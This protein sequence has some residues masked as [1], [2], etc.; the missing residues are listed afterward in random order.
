MSVQGWTSP[1]EAWPRHERPLAQKALLA[2]R[3]AD[4]WLKKASA[5]S[6]VWGVITCGEPTLPGADRCSI[7]VMCTSGRPDGSST[8]KAI[9]DFIRKCP[10]H[11]GSSQQE[12]LLSKAET[13]VVSAELCVKA[14]EALATA[15]SHR[16]LVEDYLSKSYTDL[17][18]ADELIERAL[19]EDL[20]AD[21]AEREAGDAAEAAGVSSDL[22]AVSIAE[23]ASHRAGKAIQFVEHD[24]SRRARVI[25]A[26]CTE[27]KSRASLLRG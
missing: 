6:K 21:E 17:A 12:D 27:V 24:T 8:K 7:S 26:R 10:H 3:L 25:R 4:W 2:A 19:E 23:Q 11:R 15:A 22:A 1:S 5:R 13:L 9:D 16:D 14:A 20:L 18:A